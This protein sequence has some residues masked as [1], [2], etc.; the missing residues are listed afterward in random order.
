MPVLKVFWDFLLPFYILFS[1][2]SILH[3][4]S[5][6]GLLTHLDIIFGAA[7]AVIKV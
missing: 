4:S 3:H 2:D 1:P 6:K 5:W 7:A